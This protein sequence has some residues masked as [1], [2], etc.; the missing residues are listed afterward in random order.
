MI[1]NVCRRLEQRVSE[2]WTLLCGKGSVD[3]VRVYLTVTRKWPYFGAKLFIAKVTEVL[4]VYSFVLGWV[5]SL[6]SVVYGGLL[7]IDCVQ[8]RWTRSPNLTL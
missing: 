5:T 1:L 7:G 3:C 2:A 6:N 8:F 4:P